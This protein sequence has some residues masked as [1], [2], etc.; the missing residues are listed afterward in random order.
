MP[1]H[2]LMHHKQYI[3]TYIQ[4]GIDTQINKQIKE[5]NII[6]D[7]PISDL[8]TD[9]YTYIEHEDDFKFNAPH[10]F[11][12][13]RKSDGAILV[14]VDM[15][16]GPIKECGVNG[17]CNEDLLNMVVTRL[18]GFQKSEFACTENAIALNKLQEA[19]LW[20]HH[21]TNKRVKRGVE[22]THKV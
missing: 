15:Q 14:K 20:L 8:N 1:T 3:Y 9:N 17:C 12:V 10:H 2:L 19:L 11:A 18:E 7:L 4:T 22:G 5:I 21:R 16:E 13:K 6:M